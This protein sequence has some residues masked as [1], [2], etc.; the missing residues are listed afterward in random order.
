MPRTR[1]SKAEE[2]EV[3][4]TSSRRSKRHTVK[5]STSEVVVKTEGPES[6]VKAGGTTTQDSV[7]GNCVLHHGLK[8]GFVVHY[9]EK[10]GQHDLYYRVNEKAYLKNECPVGAYKTCHFKWVDHDIPQE[11]HTLPAH[12]N[13]LKAIGEHLF[14]HLNRKYKNTVEKI[15]NTQEQ[16][17]FA[18]MKKPKDADVKVYVLDGKA[19]KWRRPAPQELGGLLPLMHPVYERAQQLLHVQEALQDMVQSPPQNNTIR[20]STRSQH[21]EKMIEP[22]LMVA[23]PMS[24]SL[25]EQ[26]K[27]KKKKKKT[28]RR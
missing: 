12:F 23:E 19:N 6:C 20:R 16:Q 1:R 24:K 5:S 10:T 2:V 27:Q 18:H 21:R 4:V 14:H 25:P 17:W 9:N 11:V 13:C 28:K 22:E 15:S 8:N 26:K 3:P 7:Q